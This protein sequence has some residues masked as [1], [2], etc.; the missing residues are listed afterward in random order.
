MQ[1]NSKIS[2]NH[3]IIN[4]ESALLSL[5]LNDWIDRCYN[6][7]RKCPPEVEE[8]IPDGCD[9]SEVSRNFGRWR[10]GGISLECD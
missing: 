8:L 10:L 2:Q 1:N 5:V 9:I 7:S 6:V 3:V 4:I